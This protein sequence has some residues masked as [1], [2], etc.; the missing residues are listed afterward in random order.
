[1]PINADAAIVVS[2]TTP[3]TSTDA[4]ALMWTQSLALYDDS[5]AAITL[6]KPLERGDPR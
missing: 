2:S 3:I 6:R 5:V 4:P 1:L